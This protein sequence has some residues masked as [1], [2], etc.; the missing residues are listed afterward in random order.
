MKIAHI[1]DPHLGYRA[2]H[3]VN[4]HGQNIREADTAAAYDQAIRKTIEIGPDLV[5][6]AGDVVHTVRP[7][8][9]VV[10][11]AFRGLAALREGLP[12]VPILIIAGN[13]DS[14]KSADTGNILSL[15][16]EIPGVL[17]VT[18]ASQQVY[19]EELDTSVLCVPHN[20]LAGG[21]R[22]ALLPD[23]QASTNI[24][25]MHGTVGG[26]TAEQKIR[27][28]SEY[29]GEVIKDKTIGPENWDYVALG[30]YHILTDLAPNMWYA[31]ATERTS[32]NIWIEEGPK[33]F[34]SYDT[35]TKQATFHELD[36][37]PMVDLP[38]IDAK[39]L[40]VAEINERIRA[41]AESI[42]G[43]IKGKLVR[44]VIRN[45]PRQVARELD[46]SRIRTYRAEALHYHLDTRAP[47]VAGRGR[48]GSQN[49]DGRALKRTVEDEVRDFLRS[50]FK[51]SSPSIKTSV[52]VSLAETY[53]ENAGAEV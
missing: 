22:T 7:S 11:H 53:M 17:P 28:L 46:F 49:D 12:E 23:G 51:P 48:P 14:P 19:I 35:I 30:H 33:G 43:G 2:Y 42:E 50:R 41:G 1:A 38:M 31:G 26:K 3:R 40:A 9:A 8:N 15:F 27:F 4:R 25:M 45:L 34:L 47:Q 29:G 20:A 36:T 32:T 5:L 44:Q 37:R 52:L 24:L 39:G 18:H 21:L 10:A 13:H 16:A 6:I